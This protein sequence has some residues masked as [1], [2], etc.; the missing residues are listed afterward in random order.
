MLNKISV[1][2]VCYNAVATIEGTIQSVINQSYDNI[3]YIVIDGASTDG[4]VDVIK[5]Y[6]DHI[7]Y[8]VSEPD[9][10]IYDAMNKGVKVATGDWI[11]ILN[12][13][14]FYADKD[15]LANSLVFDVK[16]VDVVYGDSI[17]RNKGQ[18]I[19][20]CALENVDILGRRP[21][22]RHG[23]SLV[24]ADVHKTHLYDLSRKDL[25]YALDWEMIHRLYV[26]GYVFKKVPVIIE[27]FE[28]EGESNH[29][30]LNNWY[31]YKITSEGTFNLVK[32]LRFI[33]GC[34][35]CVFSRT[36]FYKAISPL[37]EKIK[38]KYNLSI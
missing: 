35:I 8:Y 16:G 25:G 22:Y 38:N 31:N 14:D 3:E 36:S 15:S 28:L 5:R 11:N 6:I 18:F 9:G 32:F 10:G 4:T 21:I 26:E 7:D 13:G 30:F 19:K 12:S 20:R 33:L 24:R 34:I 29:P 2:T 23:S 27:C 37:K 1:I 17:E